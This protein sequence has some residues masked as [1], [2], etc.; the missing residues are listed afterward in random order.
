[1]RIS[2]SSLP[3]RYCLSGGCRRLP[4]INRDR[5]KWLPAGGGFGGY[6]SRA[7]T[8]TFRFIDLAIQICGFKTNRT[9]FQKGTSQTGHDFH[10][11]KH[12]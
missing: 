5:R 4:L 8:A 3:W 10:D 2:V 7:Q 11:L 6:Q 1:M 12:E 9:G